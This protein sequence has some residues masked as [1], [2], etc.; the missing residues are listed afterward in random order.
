MSNRLSTQDITRLLQDPSTAARADI[1]GKVAGQYR[2]SVLND[3]E[4]QIAT[5]IFRVMIKDAAV[6]VREALSHNL[7]ATMDLPHDLALALARD[8]E[9]V[10][11]PMIESS[12]VL[13]EDDLVE[14]VQSSSP[15]KQVAVARR[16]NVPLRVADALIESRN[17]EAVATLVGNS[18]AELTEKALLK[19]IDGYADAEQVHEGIVRRQQLPITVA[20]RLVAIVS[21]SL[22]DY[23][24]AHHELS[25]NVAADLILESRERATVSLLSTGANELDVLKLVRQLQDNGRLT[26]SLILR[27]LCTGDLGL[28]EASVAVLANAPIVNVRTLIHDKGR[29]GLW[30]IYMRT[31]LPERLYPAFRVA[32]DVARETGYDGGERDSE[33]R[34]CRM[35]ERILTQYEDLGQ[36][37]LDYLLKKLNQIAA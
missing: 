18:G 1:A 11:L 27:A 22:R 26:P 34:V 37:N 33:R 10:A 9:S 31:G 3:T 20:E 30:S 14:I 25:P 7:K 17:D 36:D 24:V 21:E 23:L 5:D 29:L 28:F 35:I 2:D 6:R 12:T 16:S 13:T 19:V 4:R 15:S 32:V 8:V